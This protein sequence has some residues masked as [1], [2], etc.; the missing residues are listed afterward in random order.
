[1]TGEPT[2]PLLVVSPHRDDAV[3]SCGTLLAARPGAVVVT[4]FAGTP[5]DGAP[6]EDADLDAR[7][8]ED[9][10]ALALLGAQPLWLDFADAP[11]APPRSAD[12]VVA[13]LEAVVARLAPASVLLPMGLFH[14]DHTL[15]HEAAL[16]VMRRRPLRAEAWFAYE[17]VPY[18]RLDGWLQR[19]LARLAVAGVTATPVALADADPAPKRRALDCHTGRRHALASAG[20][21]DDA[22]ATAPEGLWQLRLRRR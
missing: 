20:H 19:R 18:R 21:P 2:P 10:Q 6:P 5:A 12:A 13:A 15:V 11:D 16:R 22:D 1:M 4:V 8:R 9:T 14:E 17:D 7:R 3:L